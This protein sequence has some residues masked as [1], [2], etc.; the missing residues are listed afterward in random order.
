MITYREALT[1]WVVVHTQV[2]FFWAKEGLE[3]LLVY[4]NIR[5]MLTSAL[6]TLVNNLF[7]ENFDII[8]ME[9]EKNC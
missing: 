6:R 4:I 2:A 5:E 3:G 7:Y 8:F 1:D 9:N